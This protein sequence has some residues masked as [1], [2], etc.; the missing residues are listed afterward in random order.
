MG[1]TTQ[2]S[3]PF[4]STYYVFVYKYRRNGRRETFK[5]PVLISRIEFNRHLSHLK[6]LLKK[7]NVECDF[8]FGEKNA[9]NVAARFVVFASVN[10]NSINLTVKR[11]P[12]LY[13]RNILG[14]ISLAW[15]LFVFVS[16]CFFFSLF[17]TQ[18]FS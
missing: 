14:L 3:K 16:S 2:L 11:N 17:L 7:S 13:L 18:L 15:L 5:R 6:S 8:S 12:K 9:L 4:S 10:R 1:D